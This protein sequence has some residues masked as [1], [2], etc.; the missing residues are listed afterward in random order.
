[1]ANLPTDPAV[2]GDPP[3][4]LVGLYLLFQPWSNYS[5][6][7]VGGA[8]SAGVA[9]IFEVCNLRLEVIDFAL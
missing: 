5:I 9:W 4:W 6:V 2:G 3:S 8:G 1:M 7:L